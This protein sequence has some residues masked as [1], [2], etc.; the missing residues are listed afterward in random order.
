[1][2]TTYTAL[3]RPLTCIS[4]WDSPRVC[5]AG[6]PGQI[7]FW[8]PQGR[9]ACCHLHC[10]ISAM[11]LYRGCTSAMCIATKP[12]IATDAYRL[13]GRSGIHAAPV[14]GV[15]GAELSPEATGAAPAD[16]SAAPADCP[17]ATTFPPRP[18][19][20][21]G[22]SP[23]AA[24]GGTAHWVTPQKAA[25]HRQSGQRACSNKL[26]HAKGW[27]VHLSASSITFAWS[28]EQPVVREPSMLVAR[29][30]TVSAEPGLACAPSPSTRTLNPGTRTPPS[31]CCRRC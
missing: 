18:L 29:K 26:H 31:R 1:M 19:P 3:R 6:W 8:L 12:Q 14:A 9:A 7:V 27:C 13:C 4:R 30:R 15:V 17:V 22:L 24:C 10:Q 11:G 23:P 25:R 21:A 5:S 16:P 28:Q 2:T 20:L